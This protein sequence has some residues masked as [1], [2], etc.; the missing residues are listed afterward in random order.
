MR[1]RRAKGRGKRDGENVYSRHHMEG[2]YTSFI[3]GVTLRGI[4]G[5]VS[6]NGSPLFIQRSSLSVLSAL[7]P[8]TMP[9]MLGT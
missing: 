1:L 7:G 2:G 4:L 6:S 5:V 9:R 3:P 8:E